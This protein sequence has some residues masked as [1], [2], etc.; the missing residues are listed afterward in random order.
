M[1]F[2]YIV[3]FF[4]FFSVIVECYENLLGTTCYYFLIDLTRYWLAEL[5]S[6]GD[7]MDKIVKR[8]SSLL[9]LL[10]KY[11]KILFCELVYE[12]GSSF[13]CCCPGTQA[14]LFVFVRHSQMVNN[15]LFAKSI[16]GDTNQPAVHVVWNIIL[17]VFWR[18]SNYAGVILPGMQINCCT[19]GWI[20]AIRFAIRDSKEINID[21]GFL[22]FIWICPPCSTLMTV[23]FL[24]S[25]RI[26]WHRILLFFQ[27][28]SRRFFTGVHSLLMLAA[29]AGF[30]VPKIDTSRV[31]SSAVIRS[32]SPV[33]LY[34]KM[35]QPSPT[36]GTL[37]FL[38]ATNDKLTIPPATKITEDSAFYND[39]FS[40]QPHLG[41]KETGFSTA[42][43]DY[44]AYQQKHS[45]WNIH[46]QESS[47]QS[48][49]TAAKDYWGYGNSLVLLRLDADIV[50]NSL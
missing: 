45:L 36:T 7:D 27:M 13:L 30:S 44:G 26:G 16:N 28:L 41:S 49:F 35:A 23:P 20:S 1:K 4:L 43:K 50:L 37:P 10:L 5:P 25:V 24:A 2:V 6:K 21:I 38:T 9:K 39:V 32:P 33:F 40:F 8:N 48:S 12:Y 29:R 17:V 34:N 47:L 18:C 3:N 31:G 11:F 46:Q 42:E 19:W 22:T 14:V 15:H